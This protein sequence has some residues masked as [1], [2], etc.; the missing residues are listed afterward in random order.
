[1]KSQLPNDHHKAHHSQIMMKALKSEPISPYF[2]SQRKTK[3]V[4]KKG[5]KKES[6]TKPNIN[7]YILCRY[8][9]YLRISQNTC[10]NSITN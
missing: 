5:K 1:M 2:K 9:V 8:Y 7:R 3:P 4:L 6:E 10:E